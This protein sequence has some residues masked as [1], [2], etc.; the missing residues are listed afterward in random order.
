[1]RAFTVAMPGGTKDLEY[2]AYVRLLNDWGID[3]TD[4]PRVLEKGMPFRWLYAWKKREDAE[5]F[6]R[7]L[8]VQT[9]D[10]RWRVHEFSTN[11]LPQGPLGPVEINV[12]CQRDGC[13][14]VLHP[15]SVELIQKK[16]PQA[17]LVTSVFLGHDTRMN[18]ERDRP[19]SIWDHVAMILTGLNEEQLNE[20]GGY[21]IYDPV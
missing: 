3:V 5:R 14:Y 17:C 18:F 10:K 4:V 1:M 20:L 6:A 12:G 13:T 8:R 11:H 2:E 16:F 7:E 15:N 21:R 19:E 9:R